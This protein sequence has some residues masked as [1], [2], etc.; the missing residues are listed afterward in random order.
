MKAC[1]LRHCFLFSLLAACLAPLPLSAAA[2]RDELLRLVP[3]DVGFCL[4]VQDLR[5]HLEQLQE[6]PFV[7]QFHRSPLG[8]VLHNAKEMQKLLEVEKQLQKSF[9]LDWARLRDD[10]FGD[11]I[12]LAYRPG[13]PDKPGQEQ[14]LILIRARDADFLT[15][16]VDR[17]NQAQKGA[18]ELQ[19]VE[20]RQHQGQ[21]YFR[22]VE[23]KRPATPQAGETQEGF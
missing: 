6:S 20:P 9:R 13:P 22:R 23:K 4:V 14:D 17:I 21:K 8:Q 1:S 15:Q 7:Q 2:P 3:E 10:I 5:G 11:A 19:E 16:L 12:V 18:G